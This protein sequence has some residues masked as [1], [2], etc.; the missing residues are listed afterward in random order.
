MIGVLIIKVYLVNP[1]LQRRRQSGFAIPPIPIGFTIQLHV[2]PPAS[3]KG[4][5]EADAFH[6]HS[7]NLSCS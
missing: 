3:R 7:P 4:P 1:E 5:I 6:A 2:T